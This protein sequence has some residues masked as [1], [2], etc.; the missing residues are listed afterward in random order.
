MINSEVGTCRR[1]GA[2]RGTFS[3]MLERIRDLSKGRLSIAYARAR[4]V[5]GLSRVWHLAEDRSPQP[6]LKLRPDLARFIVMPCMGLDASRT[7]LQEV[8]R[9][10]REHFMSGVCVPPRF[11][12]ETKRA[13]ADHETKITAIVGAPF[14]DQTGAGKAFDSKRAFKRG[15]DHVDMMLALAP[16][17]DGQHDKVGKD[18][19]TVVKAAGKRAI[20]VIIGSSVSNMKMKSASP[21]RLP[22]RRVPR[23]SSSAAT[24][25]PDPIT[26]FTRITRYPRCRRMRTARIPR[27]HIIDWSRTPN[28][29]EM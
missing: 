2:R 29:Y 3:D 7:N 27:P 26:N 13:L 20:N 8:C 15:A 24:H 5:E 10:A 11:V 19:Q 21:Q 6:P 4:A 16:L 28:A 1:G 12:K 25:R 9:R 18:I 14:G 23:V 22:W 17:R